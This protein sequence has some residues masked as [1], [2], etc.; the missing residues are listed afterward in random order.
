M[1]S[2]AVIALFAVTAIAQTPDIEFFEKR[3]RPLF[4]S[5]CY[6]CHGD[7]VKM[8]GL[9]LS[10]AA[11][12]THALE[13]GVITKGDPEKSRMYRALCFTPIR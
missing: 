13:S 6:G 12:L 1:R 10:S 7:K 8:G 3:I 4:A 9:T 11:G 5:K 2:L